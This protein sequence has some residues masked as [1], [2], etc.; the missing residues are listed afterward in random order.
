MFKVTMNVNWNNDPFKQ[1]IK[2]NKWQNIFLNFSDD[3]LCKA[4]SWSLHSFPLSLPHMPHP[5]SFFTQFLSP[6]YS[7][8]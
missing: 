5:A 2:K 4:F 8:L 6:R 1:K 7:R 3:I